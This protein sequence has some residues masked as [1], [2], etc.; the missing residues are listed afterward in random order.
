LYELFKTVHGWLQQYI[1][2]FNSFSKTQIGISDLKYVTTL[3]KLGRSGT[4]EVWG[5]TVVFLV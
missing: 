2:S 1:A 4:I 5:I 3:A